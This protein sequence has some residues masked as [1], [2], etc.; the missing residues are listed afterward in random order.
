ME[1]FEHDQLDFAASQMV[2]MLGKM[3]D[4]ISDGDTLTKISKMYSKLVHELTQEGFS[5][6]EAISIATSIASQIKGK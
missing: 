3:L 4:K 2:E 6:E 1:D 5:R